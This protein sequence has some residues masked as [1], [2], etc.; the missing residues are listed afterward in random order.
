MFSHEGF[1]ISQGKRAYADGF[2]HKFGANLDIANNTYES[3]WTY[4]GLYP[5]SALDNPQ[6]LYVNSTTADAGSITLQGLDADYNQI[7]ETLT[8]TGTAFVNTQNLFK[9]IFRAEYNSPLGTNTGSILVRAASTGGTVVCQVE[10]GKGQTQMAVY[11]VPAGYTAYGINYLAGT[12]KANETI[13]EVYTRS[14]GGSF[15]VRNAM[16]INNNVV[17]V[18]FPIPVPLKEKTDIDFRAIAPNGGS[19]IVN[20]DLILQR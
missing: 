8:L 14:E 5:W 3:V 17:N 6:V 1:L 16:Q 11:T 9:R 12:G 10:A 2:V 7:S 4:G 15:R 18:P 13:V 20:F 19:V